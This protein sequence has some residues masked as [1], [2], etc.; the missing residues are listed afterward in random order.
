MPIVCKALEIERW[1]WLAGTRKPGLYLARQQRPN[2]ALSHSRKTRTCVILLST[3]EDV[4]HSNEPHHLGNARESRVDTEVQ[5]YAMRHYFIYCEGPTTLS[6]NHG[7]D[8]ATIQRVG[9]VRRKS[10]W[11]FFPGEDR[12]ALGQG[13]DNRRPH[14]TAWAGGFGQ[15]GPCVLWRPTRTS[16]II[17]I[18][19]CNWHRLRWTR[20]RPWTPN[21][22]DLYP[23]YNIRLHQ[24]P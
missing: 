12:A 19:R 20:R 22:L 16:A 23:A 21:D 10:P 24:R 3:S 13:Q 15:R 14:G 1:R 11:N 8:P 18:P 17:L 9:G 7:R 2:F 4:H 6:P 5:N